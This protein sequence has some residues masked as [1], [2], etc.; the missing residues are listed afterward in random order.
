MRLGASHLN[1]LDT[2]SACKKY[3]LQY[4]LPDV[5]VRRDH[6]EVLT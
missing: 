5:I 2:L 3:I 4:I 1:M 6:I